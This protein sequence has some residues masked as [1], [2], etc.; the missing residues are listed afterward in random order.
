MSDQQVIA[1]GGFV[2]CVFFWL[3][4]PE[5]RQAHEEFETT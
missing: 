1:A 4:E 5:N 3:K 2:H